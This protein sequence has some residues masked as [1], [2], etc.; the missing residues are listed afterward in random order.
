MPRTE[1]GEF[2]LVLGNKQLLSV[3]FIVV[4][5]LGVFFA[6]GYIAGR[7][8]VATKEVPTSAPII[9]EAS[10]PPLSDAKP[11]PELAKSVATLP[12]Q[13][14]ATEKPAA[15][16][17]KPLPPTSQPPV[18]AAGPGDPPPGTYLQIAATSKAEGDVLMNVLT[19]RGFPARL[20]QVPGQELY[21]VVV[22]PVDDAQVLAKTRDDLRSAG[23]KPFT[24]KF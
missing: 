10:K 24:R 18:T 12:P 19:K 6:M 1:D 3:F 22:G 8:T 15:I 16:P 13:E 17:P 4:V 11:S 9:V 23:F 21:R 20:A 14:K 7:N 5:L 2:E